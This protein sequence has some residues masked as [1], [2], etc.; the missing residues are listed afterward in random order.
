M[1]NLELIR[2]KLQEHFASK[3]RTIWVQSIKGKP[4]TIMVTL[5]PVDQKLNYTMLR[6]VTLKEVSFRSVLNHINMEL[7][8]IS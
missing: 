6:S 5:F 8:S 3:Y 1:E 4:N 2:T 7:G